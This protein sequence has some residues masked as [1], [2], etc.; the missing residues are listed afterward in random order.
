MAQVVGS[1][2]HEKSENLDE[3]LTAV[4]VPWIARKGAAKSN[5]T[6]DISKEGNEFT[7]AVKTAIMNNTVKFVLGEEFEEKAPFGGGTQKVN[8]IFGAFH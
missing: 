8:K 7:L 4:G 3:Y 6:I 5:P 1:Y 2:A